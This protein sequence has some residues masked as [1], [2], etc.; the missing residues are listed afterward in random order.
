MSLL[1]I[2]LLLSCAGN[3]LTTGVLPEFR[4]NLRYFVNHR[5]RGADLSDL[6]SLNT[7]CLVG[8]L[9]VVVFQ[10]KVQRCSCSLWFSPRWEYILSL[11]GASRLNLPGRTTV[12]WISQQ[13]NTVKYCGFLGPKCSLHE[14]MNTLL[15]MQ[16]Q[17]LLHS[18]I[19]RMQCI[20]YVL[21]SKHCFNNNNKLYL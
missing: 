19:Y 3:F 21:H 16:T 11:I 14:Y 6:V 20:T 2:P 1:K 7:C 18:E 15:A 5:N 10:T 13:D 4:A 9:N 17:F 8:A 12:Y